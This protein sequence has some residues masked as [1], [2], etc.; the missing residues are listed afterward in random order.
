MKFSR[1]KFLPEAMYQKLLNSVDVSR[2]YTKMNGD[3]ESFETH[4]KGTL[5]VNNA[6]KS[7]KVSEVKAVNLSRQHSVVFSAIRSPLFR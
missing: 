2:S 4:C 6:Q 5:S 1:V 3:G 7:T